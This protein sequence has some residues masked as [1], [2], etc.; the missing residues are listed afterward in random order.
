MDFYHRA[1]EDCLSQKETPSTTSHTFDNRSIV[2]IG[3]GAIAIFVVAY[4]LATSSPTPLALTKTLASKPKQPVE[5]SEQLSTG[6]PVIQI[7][8]TNISIKPLINECRQLHIRYNNNRH[9]PRFLSLHKQLWDGSETYKNC[10]QEVELF[11]KESVTF[12]DR[13]TAVKSLKSRGDVILAKKIETFEFRACWLNELNAIVFMEPEDYLDHDVG[14]TCCFE[15]LNAINQK[16]FDEIHK[17]ACKGKFASEGGYHDPTTSEEDALDR[18][19]QLYAYAM[20]NVEAHGRTLHIKIINEAINHGT[21]DS[22]WSWN[23]G[24]TSE[25]PHKLFN[26]SLLSSYGQEH[27][28]YWKRSYKEMIHP[29]ILQD[30]QEVDKKE[31]LKER[32]RILSSKW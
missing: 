7:Q 20:E 13:D 11:K 15:L 4:K 25:L 17:E 3:I 5:N 16:S 22:S 28:E 31:A 24:E 9:I 26:Q 10:I 19:S 23:E 2:A 27:F 1:S 29:S 30:S 8:S 14:S 21:V 12:M 18:A 32:M 6:N